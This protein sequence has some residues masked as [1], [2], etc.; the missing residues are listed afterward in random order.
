MR[1]KEG[2]VRRRLKVCFRAAQN[3]DNLSSQTTESRYAA[4][5]YKMYADTRI[6]RGKC[7]H[8]AGLPDCPD[9]ASHGCHTTGQRPVVE[10][11]TR[12]AWEI[13][14][15]A[16]RLSHRGKRGELQEASEMGRFGGEV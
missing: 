6:W 5:L 8:L 14:R 2:I 10:T 13:T 15:A 3:N 11:T 7:S 1:I 4:H 16:F 9:Q 12:L